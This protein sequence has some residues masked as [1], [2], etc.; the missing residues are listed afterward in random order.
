[1]M[2]NRWS[3]TNGMD[4]TQKQKNRKRVGASKNCQECVNALGKRKERQKK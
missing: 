2:T 3:T 1:M 4:L